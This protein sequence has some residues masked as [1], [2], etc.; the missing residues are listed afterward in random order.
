LSQDV[1]LSV[2]YARALQN[3]EGEHRMPHDALI[4]GR[5]VGLEVVIAQ[6]V[7]SMVSGLSRRN[8]ACAELCAHGIKCDAREPSTPGAESSLS[9]SRGEIRVVVNL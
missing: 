7:A 4:R 3:P 2:E 5:V 8:S 1:A 6:E 9:A